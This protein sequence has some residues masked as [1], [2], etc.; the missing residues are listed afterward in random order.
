[1]PQQNAAI[2]G[3]GYVLYKMQTEMAIITLEVCKDEEPPV[4]VSPVEV[5]DAVDEAPDTIGTFR[6]HS[7]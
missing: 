3:G 4:T 1:M 6:P 2:I 5:I 7:W